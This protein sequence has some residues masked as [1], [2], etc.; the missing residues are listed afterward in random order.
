MQP[1][2]TDS[3][4]PEAPGFVAPGPAELAILFRFLGARPVQVQGRMSRHIY[5]RHRTFLGRKFRYRGAEFGTY[6]T[7]WCDE[8]EVSY[9]TLM[10]CRDN[11]TGEGSVREFFLEKFTGDPSDF[12]RDVFFIRMAS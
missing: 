3:P 11:V 5:P 1:A 7:V 12:L 4:A 6:Q 2:E 9:R 8:W 10:V